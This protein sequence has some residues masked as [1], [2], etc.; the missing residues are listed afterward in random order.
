MSERLPASLLAGLERFATNAVS[1]HSKFH[2]NSGLFRRRGD[3][4][5]DCCSPPG[6][7]IAGCQSEN[8]ELR[9]LLSHREAETKELRVRNAEKEEM[10]RQ[11]APMLVN[12]G[13][14]ME[15]VAK[16]EKPPTKIFT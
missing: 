13:T 5:V 14:T 3:G 7:N 8:G 2:G 12:A 11:F 4:R 10:L 15:M 16:N 9:N 6:W 1:L